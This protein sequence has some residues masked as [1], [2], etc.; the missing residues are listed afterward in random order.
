MPAALEAIP[1]PS[2]ND[3]V[4]DFIDAFFDLATLKVSLIVSYINLASLVVPALS[5]V[6]TTRSFCASSKV[7][8]LKILL[9]YNNLEFK[10]LTSLSSPLT[11]SRAF[12][13]SYNSSNISSFS[14][15][16]ASPAAVPASSNAFNTLLAVGYFAC[17]SGS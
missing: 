12:L 3:F 13:V 16:I 11:V 8:A 1:K 7:F 9:T 17:T 2:F 4:F 15:L 6:S 10:R 14:R 5:K